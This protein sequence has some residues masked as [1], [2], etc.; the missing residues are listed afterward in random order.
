MNAPVTSFTTVANLA[1]RTSDYALVAPAGFA[2]DN[3]GLWHSK[4][5]GNQAEKIAD[6]FVVRGLARD[7]K[8]HGWG[9]VLEWKD[10][11]RIS[12]RWIIS[13]ANLIG[14]GADVFR[15]LV[16]AVL[17]ISPKAPHIRLL[18]E[19][20]LGLTCNMRVR[21][22][23]QAGWY[24]RAFVLPT[25]TIG[26]TDGEQVMFD[27]SAEAA[28]YGSEGS[29]ED[30]NSTVAAMCAGNTR[31]VFAC[32]VAFAGPLND[33]LQ[34]EGGGFHF[35][36][37]SS[38]GKTTLLTAA[39]SAFGGGGRMGYAH[40]WHA[41]ENGLESIA[42]AHSGTLLVLDEM[43]QADNRSIGNTVYMLI[44]GSGRARATRNAELKGQ[45]SWRIMLL[46]SGEVTLANKIAEGGRHPRA[47]Q[48][49]RMVD[50]PADAGQGYGAYE[51]TKGMDPAVFS[52]ELK[53]AALRTY[54][55]AGPAFIQGLAGDPTAV[56]RA[57]RIRIREITR[58]L[59]DGIAPSDGQ[60]HRVAARFALVAVAGELA[61]EIL[62]LP[63]AEGA[64]EH[65]ALVCFN[66]W[67]EARGG[68]GPGELVAAMEALRATIQSH[69]ESRF[70]NLEPI[71]STDPSVPM[72][73][74]AIY[75][76]LGY[77]FT[78]N[79][80]LMWGFTATGWKKVVGSVGQPSTVAKLLAENGV[81]VTS[82]DPAC[83]LSKRIDGRPQNLIAVKASALE[84]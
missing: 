44:N 47:G 8:G 55:T 64:A 3:K 46:S 61:Q 7:P 73:H 12:R 22:V 41:T 5:E 28:R 43:G 45:A 33:L 31:A 74:G 63:W 65:A 40:S 35:V 53:N 32:S 29:L 27:G 19:F 6:P 71:A 58:R 54:G 15:P 10:H 49:A 14:G 59:L 42:R 51:D 18:K 79:G 70:R 78:H 60:A 84:D 23:K 75:D 36:G 37:S 11:D 57:A 17:R 38:V 72:Q 77:R 13:Q 50:V 9:I 39:G 69:G 68:E 24:G 66:A 34:E 30:W 25:I 80:E 56:E 52:E 67:R 76:L 21:L 48:L 1:T 82:A 20:F 16:H 62:D 4:S 81:L 26:N 83:R 2:M